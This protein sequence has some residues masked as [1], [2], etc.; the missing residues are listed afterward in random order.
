M[1][2]F[3]LTVINTRFSCFILM[4]DR[5]GIFRKCSEQRQTAA[6]VGNVGQSLHP[7]GTE[8]KILTTIGC[9]PVN[10]HIR[11]DPNNPGKSLTLHLAAS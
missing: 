3:L 10:S 9:I 7:F 2:I 1:M 11:R 6:D 5:A 4:W 8:R